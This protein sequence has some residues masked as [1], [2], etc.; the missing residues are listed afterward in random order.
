MIKICFVCLGNICRSPMAEAMFRKLVLDLGREDEFL[1]TSRGTSS[2]EY[3]N[4]IYPPAKE[5]L[6]EMG[7]PFSKHFAKKVSM[8]DYLEYDSFICMDDSNVSAMKRMFPKDTNK[9]KKLLD[10]DI[11]DPWYTGNFEATYRDLEE[12]LRALVNSVK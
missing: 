10:R 6:M 5:K 4:D 9:I 3:G 12:G 8:E 2:E 11:A 1:I 7:I